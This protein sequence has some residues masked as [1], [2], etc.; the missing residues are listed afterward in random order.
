MDLDPSTYTCASSNGLF[1]LQES[2]LPPIPNV[3]SRAAGPQQ[4]TVDDAWERSADVE[5]AFLP[6]TDLE[7]KRDLYSYAGS[8]SP[9][10]AGNDHEQPSAS[11]GP[12]PT[13]LRTRDAPTPAPTPKGYQLP[14]FAGIRLSGIMGEAAEEAILAAVERLGLLEGTTASGS[15]ED[16]RSA[17][18]ETLHVGTWSKY[19]NLPFVT[20]DT[21]HQSLATKQNLEA[22]FQLLIT[23]IVKPVMVFLE[24]ADPTYAK[25]IK[26]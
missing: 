21:V 22:L 20:S 4:D 7:G 9:T 2:T 12:A 13:W 8:N 3:A 17:Q 26:R 5:D 10:L 14:R 23:H 6:E 19:S 25:A 11:E 1:V 24:H 18:G 16:P 15:S